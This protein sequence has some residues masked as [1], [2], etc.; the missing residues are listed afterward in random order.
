MSWAQS[1]SINADII[2]ERSMQPS[3]HTR[4]PIEG[5]PR[6]CKYWHVVWQDTS[7]ASKNLVSSFDTHL[8]N[9]PK[10]LIATSVLGLNIWN[11]HV[12][13]IWTKFNAPTVISNL[14]SQ[15]CNNPFHARSFPHQ[16]IMLAHT[17]AHN[18]KKSLQQL[19]T[20][21]GATLRAGVFPHINTDPQP[22]SQSP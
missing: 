1:S 15:G 20:L 17:N 3:I 12:Q 13:N 5:I 7:K 18:S 22:N 10:G 21:S 9:R 19:S 2:S 11:V 8:S 4:P 14:L 6:R 16:S